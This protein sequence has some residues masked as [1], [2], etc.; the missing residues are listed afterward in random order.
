M[1]VGCMKQ[2]RVCWRESEVEPSCGTGRENEKLAAFKA[3]WSSGEPLIGEAGAHGWA[4]VVASAG[5]W[6]IH[7]RLVSRPLSWLIRVRHHTWVTW[8]SVSICT[9]NVTSVEPDYWC[10][11]ALLLRGGRCG[12]GVK[13]RCRGDCS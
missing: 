2:L 12:G 11:D 5:V 13:W 9:G 1:T 6:C 8:L 7:M 10:V 3:F 4:H